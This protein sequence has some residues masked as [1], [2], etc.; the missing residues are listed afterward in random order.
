[1][2]VGSHRV[3]PCFGFVRIDIKE[4]GMRGKPEFLQK[5]FVGLRAE[6]LIVPQNEIILKKNSVYRVTTEV[7]K[8][9]IETP[10][11]I[12]MKHVNPRAG[13]TLLVSKL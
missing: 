4:I 8:D 13:S 10:D 9:P 2:G 5:G 3:F 1:M 6:I 7:A 12:G 11:D